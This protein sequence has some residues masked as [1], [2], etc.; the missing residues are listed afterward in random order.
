[1]SDPAGESDD[2]GRGASEQTQPDNGGWGSQ[3]VPG[4]EESTGDGEAEPDNGG[5]SSQ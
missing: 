4:A 1:M 5:W 2:T 3:A